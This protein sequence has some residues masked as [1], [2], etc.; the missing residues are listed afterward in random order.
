M[1]CIKSI[2]VELVRTRKEWNLA[3][4]FVWMIVVREITTVVEEL[5]KMC[6][7]SFDENENFTV[8]LQ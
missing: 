6:H 8:I 4:C 5:G 3:G 1:V 7:K 2:F